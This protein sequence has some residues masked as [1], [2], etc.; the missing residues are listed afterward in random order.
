LL[1]IGGGVATLASGC[2][3]SGTTLSLTGGGSGV[4]FNTPSAVGS[5]NLSAGTLGGTSPI[6]VTGLLTLDGG[7]VTN[8]LITANGGLSISGNT[9]LSGSKLVNP[10]I[11]LWTAG[12]LTGINGAVISNLLG[13]TFINTFDDH[14][15]T[16]A[17]ATPLF[18][19]AGSFQKTNGTAAFGTTSIDFQFM[20][21]G[22]VEVQ[23]NTLRYSVN[24]QTAGLTLLDG[25]G[26][27]AQGQ[28]FQFLGGSLVGTGLV[29]VANTMNVINSSSLS[30]G[31][32]LGQLDITGNYQQ[33][34]SGSLNIELGGYSPGASFDLV[35]VA[36]GGGGG[37]ATLG[38]TLN[39]TLANGFSPTNGASFTFL[40]ASSRVGSFAAFTYPSNDIGMAVSYDATS[41]KVTV[42]NLKPV[43]ANPISDPPAVT[44]G[45][46]FNFQ[47]PANTFTDP[48]GDVLTYTA[49]GFPPGVA[50]TGSTRNV[51]RH[52]DSGG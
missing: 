39:V 29:T 52:T 50:F 7:T 27:A 18:V 5:L 21:T 43:V 1:T 25:G 32:P 47:F 44:Y 37:V 23:T 24:Q 16:G 13:A 28:P 8:A 6:S 12:N 45:Q 3:V 30:P 33:T 34:A 42:S 20:N 15:A 46:A 49:S 36:A 22:T 35:T 38:G 19:N 14:A 40:T 48:D 9:T 51:F 10:A 17:G 26:L 11:A 41:A 2:N 31:F 4:L